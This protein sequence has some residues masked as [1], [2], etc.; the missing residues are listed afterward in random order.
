M[1]DVLSIED[2]VTIECHF[3]M[4]PSFTV[5]GGYTKEVEERKIVM[6]NN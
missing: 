5:G 3:R 1:P 4:P 2:R 6:E